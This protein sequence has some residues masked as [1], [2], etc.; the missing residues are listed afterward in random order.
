VE[1]RFKEINAY[2][3]RAIPPRSIMTG[4][5]ILLAASQR[6]EISTERLRR[7]FSGRTRANMD[8]LEEMFGRRFRR[9]F[10]LSAR[11]SDVM[12]PVPATSTGYQQLDITMTRHT[13]A[14]RIIQITAIKKTAFLRVQTGSVRVAGAIRMV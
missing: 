12:K 9:L 14:P 3:S 5:L 10:R 7:W 6:R 8:D 13:A 1:E 2:W 4:C 11:S